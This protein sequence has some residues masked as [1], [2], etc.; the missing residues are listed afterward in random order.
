MYKRMSK[1]KIGNLFKIDEITERN[2][3]NKPC[4]EVP[5]HLATYKTRYLIFQI[6]EKKISRK[7]VN[8]KEE[9][10]MGEL[11]EI[12]DQNKIFADYIKN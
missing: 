11:Q 6:E 1:N 5:K 7:N 8:K 10:E 2:Y 12:I 3:L 4:S 9:I